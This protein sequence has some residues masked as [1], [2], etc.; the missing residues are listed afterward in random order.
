[1]STENQR[2][3][4]LDLLRVV[5]IFGVILVH[6]FC[7]EYYTASITSFNWYVAVVG[8]SLLHR[9]VP[10]FIMISGAL[11]LRPEKEITLKK[12]L[13]KN[14]PRLLLAYVFWTIAYGIVDTSYRFYKGEAFSIYHLL[15]PH[16]HLWFLPLLMGVYLLIPL[17]RKISNEERLLKYALCLWV[18]YATASCISSDSILFNQ[19]LFVFNMNIVIGFAGYFLLGYY[20][21]YKVFSKKQ[22]LVIYIAGILSLLI[23]ITGNLY[24]SIS[25]GQTSGRFLY[26]MTPF[27]IIT[28]SAVF[29]LIKQISPKVHT[30]TRRFV[31]YVRN[32]MFGIYLIHAFWLFILNQSKFR[33]L[34]N[35]LLTLPIIAI[36]IFFLSLYTTKL[37]KMI[38][39]LK[40]VVE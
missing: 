9:N 39:G 2:V 21:S 33:D 36:S 7:K 1:M 10:F 27:N 23:T 34:G 17:L 30:R 25:T 13:L 32:D 5:A 6:V 24:L 40:K 20:L 22:H 28:A 37:I 4:Y 11:F 35:H 12:L 3:F 8:D 15:S 38:P 31:E 18:I 26:E 14:I 29:V 16:F 19:F